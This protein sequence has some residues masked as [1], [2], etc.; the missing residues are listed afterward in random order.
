MKIIYIKILV[1]TLLFGVSFDLF[2]QNNFVGSS[3]VG[4]TKMPYYFGQEPTETFNDVS[5]D[6]D[7]YYQKKKFSVGFNLSLYNYQK[8]VF[9]SSDQIQLNYN[10]DLTQVVYTKPFLQESTGIKY[11]VFSPYLQYKIVNTGKFYISILG[12]VSYITGNSSRVRLTAVGDGSPTVVGYA[13]SQRSEVSFTG[14]GALKV[15]YKIKGE[16]NIGTKVKYQNTIEYWSLMFFIES[17][18]F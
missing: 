17:S 14:L 8:T 5:Y 9:G 13:K 16:T 10:G 18:L 12:G 15:A 3:G 1:I 7:V 4:I 11:T 2:G 6:F